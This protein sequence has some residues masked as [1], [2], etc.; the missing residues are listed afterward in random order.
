MIPLLTTDTTLIRMPL[1]I[2]NA[3]GELDA[4]ATASG[5][6]LQVSVNGGAWANAAGTLVSTGA[7]AYYYQGVA[8]DAVARGKLSVKF[9]KTGFLT[10]IAVDDVDAPTPVLNSGTAQAGAASTITLDAGASGTNDLYK[11]AIIT[12]VGGTGVGQVNTITAYVGGTK[13]ATVN[14]AWAINPDNTSKYVIGPAPAG[15]NASSV[16]A[17]VGA[18][19]VEG[20]YTQDDLMRL[21]VGI[22]A[23]RTTDY[24]TDTITAKSLNGTKTRVTWTVD[25]TGRLTVTPGDLT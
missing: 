5:S 20:A 13:V 9:A 14:R 12:I 17:A 11:D 2:Y 4:T 25:E 3:L 22:F 21:I 1:V 8:A 15:A 23:G 10:T 7:G 6:E 16:A 24:T 18:R 19:I